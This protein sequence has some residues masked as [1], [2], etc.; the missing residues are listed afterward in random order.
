M[1]Q[2]KHI[3]F[4][5]LMILIYSCDSNISKNKPLD[6]GA[7]KLYSQLTSIGIKDTIIS[8]HDLGITETI[9]Y[10][11]I[12]NQENRYHV[13]TNFTVFGTNQTPSP[14][15]KSELIFFHENLKE[16]RKYIFD[17]PEELPIKIKYNNLIFEFN[18]SLINIDIPKQLPPLICIPKIGCFEQ[19]V[20]IL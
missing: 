10:L 11:G 15:G 7:I 4:T 8:H 6:I 3:T 13:F 18:N 19:T 20:I 5:L 17:L 14:K 1:T 16:F 2:V 9:Q 12:T